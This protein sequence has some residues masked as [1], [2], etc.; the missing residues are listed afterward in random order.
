MMYTIFNFQSQN[1]YCTFLKAGD[2]ELIVTSPD[3][4]KGFIKKKRMSPDGYIQVSTGICTLSTGYT[5]HVLQR[6]TF[7]KKLFDC[8]NAVSVCFLFLA[9]FYYPNVL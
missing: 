8:F 7:L 9:R 2:F 3:Y 6:L 4:G 1:L 5:L